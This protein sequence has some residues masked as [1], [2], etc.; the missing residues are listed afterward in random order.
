MSRRA[1]A[2]SRIFLAVLSHGLA[3]AVALGA[4]NVPSPA[5]AGDHAL[6]FGDESSDQ[7][8]DPSSQKEANVD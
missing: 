5:L 8:S 1:G 3:L 2:V 6:C 7:G 4:L